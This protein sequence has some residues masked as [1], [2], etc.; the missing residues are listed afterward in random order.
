MNRREAAALL[1]TL[2]LAGCGGG[3]SDGGGGGGGGTGAA[4]AVGGGVAGTPDASA[5]RTPPTP[6]LALW[7]DSMVPPLARA[8]ALL[9]PDR[10]VHD[11]G[12]I[13]DTSMQVLERLQAASPALRD[14]ITVFWF[15]HNNIRLS[16][17]DA[18]AQVKADLAQAIASLAPGNDDYIVL[19]LVNNATT[20]PAGTP[21]YDTVLRLNQDLAA[22]YPLHFFDIRRFMVEQA[23][24][25]TPQGA[26]DRE[27]DVPASTLRADDIHLSGFGAD[28]L[29]KRLQ[30]LL[31]AFGW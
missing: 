30:L 27:H 15:G 1:G 12:V 22:A 5:L 3:S 16:G 21:E 28:V 2:V 26:I 11:G 24:P 4:A 7:G 9:L 6:H 14:R 19:A 29:A 31:Q 23:D 13:G 17:S 8:L 18:A 10:E 20:A 25:A